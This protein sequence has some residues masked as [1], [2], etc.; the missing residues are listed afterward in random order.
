MDLEPLV[1]RSDDFFFTHEDGSRFGNDHLNLTFQEFRHKFTNMNVMFYSLTK[2]SSITSLRDYA[3]E[4]EIKS[5]SGH[6]S[7]AFE[8]YLKTSASACRSLAYMTK[9]G[10]TLTRNFLDV[11]DEEHEKRAQKISTLKSSGESGLVPRTGLEPV[12]RFTFE[13]F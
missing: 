7:K 8:R 1:N 6:T 11:M 5:L 2:H 3:T 9:A 13:G 4:G 10:K 12:R